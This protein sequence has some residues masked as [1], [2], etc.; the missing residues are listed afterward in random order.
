MEFC[1]ICFGTLWFLDKPRCFVSRT[2]DL[3]P[4]STKNEGKKQLKNE[5]MMEYDSTNMTERGQ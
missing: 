4:G 2:G 3:N 1:G 5:C